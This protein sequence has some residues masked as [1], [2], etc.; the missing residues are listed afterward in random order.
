MDALKNPRLIQAA[1]EEAQNLIKLDPTLMR[2]DALQKRVIESATE[3]HS[4]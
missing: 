3:M 4:E 2:H 1:R